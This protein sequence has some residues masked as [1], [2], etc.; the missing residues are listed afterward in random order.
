MG[1]SPQHQRHGPS[2]G[3]PAHPA[4]PPK[5]KAQK[6][7]LEIDRADNGD[8]AYRLLIDDK[9][10]PL[11]GSTAKWDDA[12]PWTAGNYGA[13]YSPLHGRS[14]AFL[15]EFPPH[16]SSIKFHSGNV[17]GHSEGCIVTP[18][19]N[20]Q[21][22]EK[23]LADAGFDK[24][25]LRFDVRNDFPIGFRLTGPAEAKRGDTIALTLELT[26]GGAPGGV[27]KDIWFHLKSAELKADT[28]YKLAAGKPLPHYRAEGNASAA[29]GKGVWVLLAQG[30]R[31]ATIRIM[32]E[33][34]KTAAPAITCTFEIDAYRIV[35]AAPGMTPYFYTPSDARAQLGTATRTGQIRVQASEALPGRPGAP[36]PAL[37]GRPAAPGQAPRGHVQR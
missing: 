2:P 8:A 4:P 1:L 20:I 9:P 25:K 29:V 15:I 33:P 31:S 30:E 36:G 32:L 14:D 18:L 35:N 11:H 7:V 22:I 37:P 10:V 6:A 23:A 17:T 26:G 3:H 13:Q 5:P 19:A 27:S 24:N 28:D 16:R 21:E 12:T 34:V